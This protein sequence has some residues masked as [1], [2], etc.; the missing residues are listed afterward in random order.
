MLLTALPP[1]PPTPNTVIRGFNSRIS[2]IFRLM[3]MG[4]SFLRER[5]QAA[6]RLPVRR[7]CLPV[8]PASKLWSGKLRSSEAL[9][10][11]S[12]DLVRCSR[13]VP[14]EGV[15]RLARFEMFEMGRLRVHRAGLQRPRRPGF[16]LTSGKP[17]NA[18]RPADR[19]RPRRESATQVPPCRRASTAAAG[20]HDAAARF[21]GER[22]RRET[23]AHHFENFFDARLDDLRRCSPRATNCG[24]SC[25]SPPTRRHRDHVALIRPRRRAH[26]H[27]TS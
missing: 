21:G 22:R 2:G 19:N 13:R 18:K 17:G 25:S 23:V 15:P 4:A 27:R 9:A 16:W 1:A 20:E 24:A 5:A 6:E 3:L 10:Q 11:P 12:A 14:V 7:W 26:C 8:R